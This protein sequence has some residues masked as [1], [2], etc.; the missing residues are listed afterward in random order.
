MAKSDKIK[1]DDASP[2]ARVVK[3][4]T[5]VE[6]ARLK[7][8]RARLSAARGSMTTY[9][10]AIIGASPRTIV[11]PVIKLDK[12]EAGERRERKDK[13]L[14]NTRLTG[15][16]RFGLGYCSLEHKFYNPCVL[17]NNIVRNFGTAA[18]TIGGV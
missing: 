16:L 9:S 17:L 11:G 7:L 5:V 4:N 10:I 12:D 8:A 13:K 18:R 1:D 14:L 6:E 15:I 2:V 3:E